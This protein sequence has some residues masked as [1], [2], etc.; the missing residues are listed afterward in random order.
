MLIELID[1]KIE[2]WRT[3]KKIND[4]YIEDDKQKL[5][6]QLYQEFIFDLKDIL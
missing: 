1:I 5:K 4:T 2:T 6:N 3:S